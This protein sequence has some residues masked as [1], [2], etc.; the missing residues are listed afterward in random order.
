[1]TLVRILGWTLALA[2]ISM[3]ATVVAHERKEG[4]AS[5]S[6]SAPNRNQL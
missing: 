4:Q 3:C 1:M 2:I 6:S 5:M